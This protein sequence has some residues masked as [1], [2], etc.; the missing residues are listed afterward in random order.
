MGYMASLIFALYTLV[1]HP[2]VDHNDNLLHTVAQL[3]A[4]GTL[5]IIWS[6]RA[7][8]IGTKQANIWLITI[9]LSPLVFA[10]FTIRSVVCRTLMQNVSSGVTTFSPKIWSFHTVESTPKCFPEWRI[11]TTKSDSAAVAHHERAERLMVTEAIDDC[12]QCVSTVEVTQPEVTQ[13][14]TSAKAKSIA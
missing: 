5:F 9:A 14:P 8:N 2:Y 12:G 10:L 4:S 7:G 3:S 13:P 11:S 6:L 1:N